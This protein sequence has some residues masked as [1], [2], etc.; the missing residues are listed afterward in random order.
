ANSRD[1]N[2]N[3]PREFASLRKPST[4]VFAQTCASCSFGGTSILIDRVPHRQPDTAHNLE[5]WPDLSIGFGRLSVSTTRPTNRATEPEPV[6]RRLAR[7]G[8][9]RRAAT[10]SASSPAQLP[11]AFAGPSPDLSAR[12]RVK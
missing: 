10:S 9:G 6:L 1:T 11:H 5:S 8:S 3:N 4:T 2:T 7:H 12:P